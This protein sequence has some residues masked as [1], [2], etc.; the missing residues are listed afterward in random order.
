MGSP[1]FGVYLNS[2]NQ[3]KHCNKEKQLTNMTNPQDLM[4]QGQEALKSASNSLAEATKNLQNFQGKDCKDLGDLK[5]ACEKA[6][7]D[8][9]MPQASIVTMICVLLMMMF[10]TRALFVRM[11]K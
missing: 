3:T 2:R 7:N 5:E 6:K 1:K 8:G 9:I 4:Q 11:Q 10:L